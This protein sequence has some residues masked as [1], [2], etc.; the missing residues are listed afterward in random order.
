MATA[1]L[2]LGSSGLSLAILPLVN[3]V[4]ATIEPETGSKS[5][6]T[7]VPLEFTAVA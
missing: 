6:P 5:A 1:T 2:G 7:T 4:E 3:H